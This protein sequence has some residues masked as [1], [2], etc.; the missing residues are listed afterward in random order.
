MQPLGKAILNLGYLPFSFSCSNI[1]P[2][3]NL[4]KDYQHITYAILAKAY[5]NH[6]QFENEFAKVLYY[7]FH[8][9]YYL[10]TKVNIITALLKLILSFLSYLFLISYLISSFI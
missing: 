7:F 5:Q 1:S 9:S 4:N 8:F 2:M 6:V 3:V 10:I